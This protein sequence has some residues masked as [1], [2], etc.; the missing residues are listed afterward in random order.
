[1]LSE[2]QNALKRRSKNG[3]EN[4]EPAKPNIENVLEKRKGIT[5][6]DAEK[7]TYDTLLAALRL[8]ENSLKLFHLDK[9][10]KFVGVVNIRLHKALPKGWE[11]P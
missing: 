10:E 6:N 11:I 8:C 7:L 1:M 5:M 3:L 4:A 2:R 9:L